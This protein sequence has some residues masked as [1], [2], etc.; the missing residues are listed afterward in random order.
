MAG[1][2][3]TS[4]TKGAESKLFFPHTKERIKIML[5]ISA[6]FTTMVTGYIL[7]RL[8]LHR[9]KIILTSTCPCRLKEEQTINRIILNWTQLENE[10]RILCNAIVRTGDTWPPPFKQ[11]T[12]RHIKT[13]MKFVRSMDFSALCT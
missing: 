4:S 8:Y 12:R 11:F 5:P 1:A 13:F 9:F 2:V 3:E 10:R 6:K 7:T